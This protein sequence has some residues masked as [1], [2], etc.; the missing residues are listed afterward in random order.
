MSEATNINTSLQ[1]LPQY[2]TVKQ[3]AAMLTLSPKT[4][5]NWMTENKCPFAYTILNKK[6]I[7]KLS[8]IQDYLD[9][10]T[11]QPAA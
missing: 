5:Y 7:F 11:I 8:D 10:N 3:T 9:R 1:V 4:L 2:L 6:P